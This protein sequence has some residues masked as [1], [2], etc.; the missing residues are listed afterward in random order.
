MRLFGC[1]RVLRCWPF[2]DHSFGLNSGPLFFRVLFIFLFLKELLS[3]GVV[4]YVALL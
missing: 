2:L 1:T 3:E 4:S